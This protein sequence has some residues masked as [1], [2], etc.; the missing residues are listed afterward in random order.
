[1]N[2]LDFKKSTINSNF[3]RKRGVGAVSNSISNDYK[4][5]TQY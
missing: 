2:Y 1:M 4:I 3:M 5:K